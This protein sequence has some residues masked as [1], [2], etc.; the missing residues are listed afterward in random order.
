MTIRNFNKL[1]KEKQDYIIN[2]IQ[3]LYYVFN[4]DHSATLSFAKVQKLTKHSTRLIKHCLYLDESF[5]LEMKD[6]FLQKT[7]R[8]SLSFQSTAILNKTNEVK[9]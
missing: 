3:S 9:Q 4:K 8:M 5:K 2:D 6:I 1:S 7:K